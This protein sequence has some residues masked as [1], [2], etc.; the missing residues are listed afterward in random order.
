MAHQSIGLVPLL[1]H[2]PFPSPPSLL[3]ALIRRRIIPPYAPGQKQLRNGVSLLANVLSF[4]LNVGKSSRL[5]NRTT[6]NHLSRETQQWRSQG[7]RMH[8][9]SRHIDGRI[10]PGIRSPQKVLVACDQILDFFSKFAN[11]VTAFYSSSVSSLSPTRIQFL[12][13][14]E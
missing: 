6:E 1:P 14:F 4:N 11:C 9:A 3:S 10:C 8:G 2:R 5:L 12:I 13:D 7:S